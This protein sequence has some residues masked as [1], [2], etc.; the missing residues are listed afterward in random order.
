MKSLPIILL[1]A[2]FIS[3]V[4]STSLPLFNNTRSNR[5]QPAT[6]LTIEPAAKSITP[7]E[8]NYCQD[9]ESWKEWDALIEEYP[10]DTDIQTLHDLRLGLCAKVERGDITIQQATDIFEFARETIINNKKS[11]IIEEELSI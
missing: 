10:G 3:S 6:N 8:E 9:Q 1:D 5:R 7:A 4:S 2:L 11:N